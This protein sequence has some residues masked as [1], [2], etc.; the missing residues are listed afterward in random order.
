MFFPPPPSSR[1]GEQSFYIL[2]ADEKL[3]A[4]TPLKVD[5][6]GGATVTWAANGGTVAAFA[7][8]RKALGI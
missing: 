4:A 5:K 7:L 1:P 6:K 2:K 3:I 8:V